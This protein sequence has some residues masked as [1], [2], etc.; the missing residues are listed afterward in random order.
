L[1][2]LSFHFTATVNHLG[3]SVGPFRSI[4]SVQALFFFL[5]AALRLTFFVPCG[6]QIGEKKTFVNYKST[7]LSGNVSICMLQYYPLPKAV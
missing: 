7:G 1:S 4:V 2:Q 6:K 5:L 3:K